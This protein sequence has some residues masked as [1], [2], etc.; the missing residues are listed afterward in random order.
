MGEEDALAEVVLSEKEAPI[1]NELGKPVGEVDINEVFEGISG[2]WEYYLDKRMI[3]QKA[4]P[5]QISRRTDVG[6]VLVPCA[7]T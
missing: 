2:M 4:N 6:S 7:F 1:D 5:S 3:G